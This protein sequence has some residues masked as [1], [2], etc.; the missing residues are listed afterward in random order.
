MRL[1]AKDVSHGGGRSTVALEGGQQ[2]SGSL[3]VDATGHSRK[4]VEFDKPFNPGAQPN[5]WCGCGW[6]A[7]GVTQAVGCRREGLGSRRCTGMVP[8]LAGMP[9]V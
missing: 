4:L 2:V 9:A 5:A 7:A 3:V 6:T 8:G 1:Q